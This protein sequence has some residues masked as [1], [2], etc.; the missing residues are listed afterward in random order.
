MADDLVVNGVI[1]A[2][3]RNLVISGTLVLKAGR[4]HGMFKSYSLSSSCMTIQYKWLK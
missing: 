4:L 3:S 2:D 1:F